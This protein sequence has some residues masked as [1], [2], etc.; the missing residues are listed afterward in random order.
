[1][2]EAAPGQTLPRSTEREIKAQLSPSDF[3]GDQKKEIK[4]DEHP[5]G[6]VIALGTFLGDARGL[7]FRNNPQDESKPSVAL[8]GTF[9]FSPYKLSRAVL[10]AGRCYL[11]SAVQDA[12]TRAM[13]DGKASPLTGMPKRGKS[14][15]I[16]CDVTV[17]LLLEISVRKTDTE[18]GY[19][20]I[21]R[22]LERI[23]LGDPLAALRER[24]QKRL[25]PPSIPTKDVVHSSQDMRGGAMENVK[26]MPTK[27]AKK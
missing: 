18:I 13:Q 7:S 22:E 24:L 10:V 5:K 26:E 21:T 6:H 12:V 8:V 27:P 20:Y 17:P 19:E 15:D 2:L 16:E 4:L 11:P 9:E 23:A 14:V 1:M 25:A 3:L